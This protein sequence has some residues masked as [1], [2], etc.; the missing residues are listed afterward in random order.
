LNL[1]RQKLAE[2][3]QEILYQTAE[4]IGNLFET[5]EQVVELINTI[6]DGAI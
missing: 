5:C 1:L 3:H 6:V 4:Y 2:N